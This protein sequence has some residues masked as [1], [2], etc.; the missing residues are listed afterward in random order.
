[1]NPILKTL[2][3]T[4]QKGWSKIFLRQTTGDLYNDDF[5]DRVETRPS[6]SGRTRQTAVGKE[7]FTNKNFTIVEKIKYLGDVFHSMKNEGRSV[8][9]YCIMVGR[10][11]TQLSTLTSL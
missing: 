11:F 4:N 5:Y 9:S 1:M 7:V 10:Y 8:W 3:S 6:D 2:S